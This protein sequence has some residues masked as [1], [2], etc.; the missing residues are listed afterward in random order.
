MTEKRD[1][2]NPASFAGESEHSQ[3]VALFAGVAVYASL[4][5]QRAEKLVMDSGGQIGPDGKKVPMDVAMFEEGVRLDRLALCLEWFHAIPN[6]GTRGGDKR[7]AMIAGANMKAEGLKTGV[8]DTHLPI[9]RHGY[10]SF[11]IEMKKPGTIKRGPAIEGEQ[12]AIMRHARGELAGEPMDGR[13]AEQ[14]AFG[15]A[16]AAEGHLTAVFDRWQD[17]LKALMWYMGFEHE[18]GWS[19]E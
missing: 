5:R 17:A 12:G 9:A 6:G 4:F 14:I 2:S 8:Y 1:L 7:S 13:S 11:W 18:L 15:R 10:H 19:L 3:Q 16:M